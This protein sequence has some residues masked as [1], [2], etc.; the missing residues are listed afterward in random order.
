MGKR[1]LCMVLVLSLLC[2]AVG[3]EAKA[4]VDYSFG[5][6][7]DFLYTEKDGYLYEVF[8]N[9]EITGNE[10]KLTGENAQKIKSIGKLGVN[11]EDSFFYGNLRS[12]VTLDLTECTNLETINDFV[13]FDKTKHIVIK[14]PTSLK[15]VGK[16]V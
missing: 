14:A 3:I 11:N 7:Y 6:E 9:S 12:A 15:R 4:A 1:M 5:T 8:T 2:G 10:I 13:G 16:N